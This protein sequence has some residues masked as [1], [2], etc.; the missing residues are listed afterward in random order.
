MWVLSAALWRQS[1]I[2]PK[3]GQNSAIAPGASGLDRRSSASRKLNANAEVSML[4][5]HRQITIATVAAAFATAAILP[6]STMAAVT[7][8]TTSDATDSSVEISWTVDDLTGVA[9]Y[10]I[11]LTPTEPKVYVGIADT[12]ASGRDFGPVPDLLSPGTFARLD[13]EQLGEPD[14]LRVFAPTGELIRQSRQSPTPGGLTA[15][16]NP[17]D[18]FSITISND[19]Y[20]LQGLTFDSEGELWGVISTAG[21]NYFCGFSTPC[22][23]AEIQ[24]HLVRINIETGATIE[25]YPIRGSNGDA[26]A[27]VRDLVWDADRGTFFT[28][29]SSPDFLNA[30]LSGVIELAGPTDPATTGVVLNEILPSRE[31]GSA[32]LTDTWGIAKSTTGEIWAL[33][34]FGTLDPI[35][36]SPDLLSISVDTG[37]ASG[38]AQPNPLQ[39]QFA[40]PNNSGNGLRPTV[41]YFLGKAMVADPNGLLVATA[42]NG[43]SMLYRRELG[44]V[45]TRTG[46]PDG[47]GEQW[48]WRNLGDS[49]NNMMG[50]A[51]TSVEPGGPSTLTAEVPA[52]ATTFR[53]TGLDPRMRYEGRVVALNQDGTDQA[54]DA[55]IA[56]V[57]LMPNPDNVS[58]A[59]LATGP[60]IS[61]DAVD[62]F[63]LVDVTLVDHYAVYGSQ[64]PFT[65]IN[66]DDVALLT[67]SVPFGTNEA[68]AAV[69]Q[70]GTWYFAVVSVNASGSSIEDV[71]PVEFLVTVLPT[72]TVNP[73]VTAPADISAE[74]TGAT[75]PVDLGSASATDNVDGDISATANNAGPFA[76]GQ[77]VVVWSATDAAG[78]TGTANQTV[79]INDTTDPV[80]VAPANLV[81]QSTVPTAV[82]TGTATA[83]D[84]SG[85]ASVTYSGPDIFD[86]GPTEVAWTC[87]D[88]SGNSSTVFQLIT[89]EQVQENTAPVANDDVATVTVD[90]SVVINVL[91]NDQDSDGDTISIQ[92]IAAAAD[93]TVQQTSLGVVYTPNPSFTGSDSFS[94]TIVDTEGAT[95]SANVNITVQ[96]L[97]DASVG[98]DV[99]VLTGQTATLDG[100][101]SSD[102]VGDTLSYRWELV[103]QPDGSS[104]SNADINNADQATASITPDV[105]GDYV[106]QLTVTAGGRTSAP[107]SIRVTAQAPNLAPVADAGS[108]SVV[109]LGNS[110]SVDGSGSTDPDQAP[111][112]LTFTWTV[113]DVPGSSAID[114]TSLIDASTAT[115][116]FTP[117]VVGTYTLRLEIFDGEATDNDTVT[118]SVNEPDPGTGG[119]ADLIRQVEELIAL[120]EGADAGD[121]SSAGHQKRIIKKLGRIST[122]L[123]REQR[124]TALFK[125]FKLYYFVGTCESS[126]WSRWSWFR[127]IKDCSLSADVKQR[128]STIYNG[129]IRL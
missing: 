83:T 28:S 110:A 2:A 24:A 5:T 58:V 70:T 91:G 67:E 37:I 82:E 48:V 1:P 128:I 19:V 113:T 22:D 121:F 3:C 86:F 102:A 16:G 101:A 32:F 49:G 122:L 7:S 68:Q 118:V 45:E 78:N 71:S 123:E 18:G 117:D 33:S 80:C 62:P 13:L 56:G 43:A 97:P 108:D 99:V 63:R 111:A 42:N 64:T 27:N 39:A 69:T 124:V 9:G 35:N 107:A 40:G 44:V 79:T 53:F 50:I 90:D 6:V 89:L 103:S 87:E 59:E 36:D 125:L 109:T 96:P 26:Y 25:S 81:V 98:D 65:N 74:A 115:A 93:G 23:L 30:P 51:L 126:R 112:A 55:A 75:T 92:S 11:E 61:W 94:Y 17:T 76:L 46:E 100:T 14:G 105:P 119:Y 127:S 106:L 41:R 129:L 95:D 116:S 84:N 88:T 15:I 57:T 54:D 21:E 20:G 77:T 104:L 66:D 34:N 12:N 4:Y 47:N 120:V 60:I 72:D 10:R 114:S 85:S 31:G 29:I 73:V 38:P 52:N 8:A